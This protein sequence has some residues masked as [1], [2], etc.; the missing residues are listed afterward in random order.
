VT[1]NSPTPQLTFAIVKS[2]GFGSERWDVPNGYTLKFSHST[3]PRSGERHYMQLSQTLD[4]TSPYTGDVS[5]QTASVSISASFPPFGWDLTHK[6]A[7][8]QAL[9]DTLLDSQV[10]IAAFDSFQS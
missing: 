10:T 2:D 9:L 1:A 8:L 7:L 5:K 6:N 4:A 3:N